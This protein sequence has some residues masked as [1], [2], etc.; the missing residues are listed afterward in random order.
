MKKNIAD[1]HGFYTHAQTCKNPL[2]KQQGILM[3]TS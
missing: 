3:T 1:M 2:L